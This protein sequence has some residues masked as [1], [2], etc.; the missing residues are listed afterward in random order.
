MVNAHRGIGGSGGFGACYGWD[1]PVEAVLLY[2]KKLSG[3]GNHFGVG[4]LGRARQF[5][6]VCDL[7][8]R[9]EIRQ[10][11][12]AQFGEGRSVHRVSSVTGPG[13]QGVLDRLHEARLDPELALYHPTNWNC[14][15]FA[16][17]AITGRAAS[18]QVNVC[19]IAA[20][21]AI[22]LLATK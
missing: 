7:T 9:D 22:L 11:S 4:L 17:W 10:L 2:R 14:E 19:G 21:G 15:T 3:P 12:L 20:M 6:S 5:I 18:Q 13:L 8:H 1:Q 16:R